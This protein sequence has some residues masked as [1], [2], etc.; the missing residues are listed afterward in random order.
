MTPRR[1]STLLSIFVLASL[2]AAALWRQA[3]AD[4]VPAATVT[5]E[6]P[7][8][9]AEV[10]EDILVPTAQTQG[11]EP[12]PTPTPEEAKAALDAVIAAAE[13]AKAAEAPT[14]QAPK[15]ETLAQE[16]VI[17][18]LVLADESAKQVLS[19]LG[20][21]LGKSVLQQQNLP[22]VRINFDSQGPIAKGKAIRAL[23]SLLTLNGISIVD[24]G[25]DFIKAV[26]TPG[27]NSQSPL[28]LDA[29]PLDLPASQR[30]YTRLFALQYLNVTQIATMLGSFVTPGLSTYAV[31]EKSNA[32]YMTDTLV[33][34]QR[35]QRLLNKIDRMPSVT[36]EIRTY[37]L[38]NITAKNA[39]TFFNNMQQ[40][41][42]KKY[43]EGITTFEA[44]ERTNQL[45][46]IA[47][48]DHY[49]LIDELIER[50][51]VDVPPFTRSNVVAIKHADATELATVIESIIS[52]QQKTKKKEQESA[53]GSG[54][55]GG[56]KGA[57]GA[58]AAAATASA[59]GAEGGVMRL[60]DFAGVVADKRSNALVTYGNKNDLAYFRE[61]I[62]QLDVVLPQVRLDIIIA[63][64]TLTDNKYRGIDML[65][66]E[67]LNVF[68][69]ELSPTSF[70]IQSSAFKGG[71]VLRTQKELENGYTSVDGTTKFSE[72]NGGSQ[73][74]D[75]VLK[76]LKPHSD[77]K[78]LAAP[79][80][81]V[82]HNQEARLFSG[83]NRPIITGTGVTQSGQPNNSVKYEKL[84]LELKVKPRIGTDGI[85]EM[86]ILQKVEDVREGT[87]ESI[88]GSNQPITDTREAKSYVSVRSGDIIVLGGLQKRNIG[89]TTSK[90]PILGFLPVIGPLFSGST[91]KET[92]TE[93]MVF[94]QAKILINPDASSADGL[95]AIKDHS[96]EEDLKFFREN[97]RFKPKLEA[98]IESKISNA[99]RSKRWKRVHAKQAEAT[100]AA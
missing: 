44:E 40:K 80:I 75:M 60:S 50:F 62:D 94:V 34:L 20:Q 14:Q 1:S 51:D 38:R 90:L 9:S 36:E 10:P 59:G 98:N 49:D 92:V 31:F 79:T 85:I 25:T 26:M 70:G 33:N 74:L 91:T 3:K 47:N 89:K 54:T 68:F 73:K 27:V 32:V 53:P 82:S 61:L 97:R 65:G 21:F 52:G 86:D 35:F 4:D 99:H 39:E 22:N 84:G 2:G 7:A 5:V 87:G 77:T 56:A 43:L 17:Q 6:E 63:E 88:G 100:P 57:E 93:L 12:E 29:N 58:G 78:V 16:E 11:E 19:L 18:S 15:E 28:F 81:C 95:D 96:L 64:V 76:A 72:Y 55:E 37:Q 13:A 30:V 46:V 23:E 42:L 45:L 66:L 67:Q 8:D 24:L 83:E 41:G 48:P 71:M 69:P